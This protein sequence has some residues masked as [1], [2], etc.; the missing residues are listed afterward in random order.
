[1][2]NGHGD[3]IYG[4]E[5][6]R[7]NFSSNVP[8]FFCHDGL[9]A[10]L[11]EC[12]Q[13]VSNY[14]VPAPYELESQVAKMNGVAADNV[15]FVNGATE[16][17]YK[18]ASA[19][20]NMN[21]AIVVPTFSEYS[22]ACVA[23]HHRVDKIA[24]LDFVADH[25]Q[26]VWLCNPNN[27]TG[28]VT[29]LSRLVDTFTSHP[30]VVFV[31][32]A[33]YDCF[34]E[35]ALPTHVQ[36]AEMHNVIMI[37]SLTKRFGV[38]G[39]RLGYVTSCSRL[40]EKMSRQRMP[41]SMGQLSTS[42]AAYLLSHVSDY[43]FDIRTLLSEAERLAQGLGSIPGIEVLNT[44]CHFMLA[45]TTRRTSAELK[46]FLATNCGILIRNAD[47][48]DGLDTSYFRVSAQSVEADDELIK[49]IGLWMRR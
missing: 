46:E 6:I 1:M 22:D 44:D 37:N 11:K 10:H 23:Y 49:Q 40:I 38:P 42:A 16:A 27:P 12:L 45:R 19:F 36:V 48:F 8:S 24:G 21:S 20:A 43:A 41:W 5:D 47:N 29:P 4:Y 18:I 17:I 15:M 32:D 28:K 31:L 7:L 39:L 26:L 35:K 9:F 14:P 25:H 30:N 33:S 34:T 3:D 13:S 2:I